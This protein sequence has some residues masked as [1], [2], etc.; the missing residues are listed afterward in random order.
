MDNDARKKG[1]KLTDNTE[2]EAE[3]LLKVRNISRFL[4]FK[5]IEKYK[6]TDK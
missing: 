5:G 4:K 3:K 6:V 1:D 2:P